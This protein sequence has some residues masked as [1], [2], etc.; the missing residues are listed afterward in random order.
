MSRSFNI[1]KILYPRKTRLDMNISQISNLQCCNLVS[2]LS[3]L[4]LQI[5]PHVNIQNENMILWGHDQKNILYSA[6][7]WPT[8][9]KQSDH[10]EIEL[11]WHFLLE[12]DCTWELAKLMLFSTFHCLD[13]DLRFLQNLIFVWTLLHLT[14]PPPIMANRGT[15]KRVLLDHRADF[16][17][18]I[19]SIPD[20]HSK[21][22][23]HNFMQKF[24][25]NFDK[26]AD[27][28]LQIG[29]CLIPFP[30]L[31]KTHQILFFR[32]HLVSR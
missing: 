20:S 25:F 19:L 8:L 23:N 29:I 12:Q 1:L 24:L 4:L 3:W 22:P 16:T 10:L 2:D 32:K 9:L 21:S 7:P 14:T 13:P 28:W 31:C 30:K 6:H 11:L 5:S 17:F 15:R 27:T 18:E 26:R